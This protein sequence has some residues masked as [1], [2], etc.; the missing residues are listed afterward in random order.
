[1]ADE[2]RTR[3]RKFGLGA[4][5]IL[6]LLATVMFFRDR[7]TGAMVTSSLGSLFI[8]T[9][10]V[11]PRLLGPVERLFIRVGG[12]LGW[13]NTRILLGLVFILLIT[14]IAVVMRIFGR[15]PLSRKKKPGEASCWQSKSDESR[16]DKMY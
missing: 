6:L 7:R 1:M 13:V 12:V 4:G 8:L 15:D 14:P 16:F 2:L 3:L 5:G 9:A 11:A 10:L